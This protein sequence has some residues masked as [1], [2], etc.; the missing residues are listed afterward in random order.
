V[1]K[2]EKGRAGEGS[3]AVYVAKKGSTVPPDDNKDGKTPTADPKKQAEEKYQW[4]KESVAYLEA[5]KEFD[6]KS[7]NAFEKSVTGSIVREFVSKYPPQYEKGFKLPDGPE[8]EL[9]GETFGDIKGRLTGYDSACWSALNAGCKTIGTRETTRNIDGKEMKVLESVTSCEEPCGKASACSNVLK[10]YTGQLGYANSLQEYV[11]ENQLRCLGDAGGANGKHQRELDAKIKNLPESLPYKRFQEFA[12]LNDWKGY[13]AAV[14]KVKQE[15]GLPEPIPSPI[16]LPWSYSSPCGGGGAVP[17]TQQLQVT[18]SADKKRVKPGD[19]VKI[20]ASVTGGKPDYTYSWTGNYSGSGSS[21]TF[22]SRN[23]GKQTLAVAVK[24]AVGTTG[25]ASVEI[26]VEGIKAGI[27]GLKDRVIYGTS[28]R[29]TATFEEIKDDK[30]ASPAPP[31]ADQARKFPTED[32]LATVWKDAFTKAM[33]ACNGKFPHTVPAKEY[34]SEKNR[35]VWTAESACHDDAREQANHAKSCAYFPDDPTCGGAGWT[36]PESAKKVTGVRVVWQS[37]P[38]ITFDPA[39][40]DGT[41]TALLDRMGP[42]NKIKIW[43]EIQKDGGVGVYST[44]GETPQQI[45]TVVPPTFKWTFEPE[46]G[47]GRIGQEVKAKITTEPADIK[48]E[49][50]NYE[51]SWPESSGRM[52]YEKNASVIGFV[53]KDPKPVKLLVAPKVPYYGESIGGAIM[54][55][56]TAE[57]FSV[58]VTG[59]RQMGPAPQIWKEGVGLVNAEQQ[60]AVFQ[61]VS[62]RAEVAPD[63]EKKPLRYQWTVTPGGCTVGNDISQEIT[64]NCSQTGSFQAKVT[65]KDRDGADLGS[66]SGTISVTISQQTLNDSAKKAKETADKTKNT[67]EAKKKLDEAKAD[68]RK[69]KLDDA[70]TKADEAAALDP[71]NKEATTLAAKW[72]AEKKRVEEQLAKTKQFI[73]ESKFL[74]A[75]R[76]LI[77]AK[78]LHGNYPPVVAAD[79]DLSEKWRTYDVTER[80]KLWEVRAAN[81]KKDFKKALELAETMRKE[82]AL[83]PAA[84]QNLKQQEDW[85]RKWEAEKETKRKTFKAA[86]EKLKNYDYAGAVKGFEEGFMNAQD[87]F[88]GSEPEYTA[89]IK[90]RDEAFLKNK[91][92][93]ELIPYVQRAAEDTSSVI[94][95]DVLQSLLKTVDEA[96]GLQPNNSK[97]TTWKQMIE[98]RLAKTTTDNQRVA[99]GRK[100]L[101]AARAAENTY[102]SQASYTQGNSG[103]WGESVELSMQEH[104][105]KAVENYRTSLQYIPDVQV[106]KHI[107]ELQTT[108]EGRKRLLANYRTSKTLLAEADGLAKEARSEQ[109]FDISQQKFAGAIEKYQKSLSLYRP[110]NEETISRIIGN[111]DIERKTNAFK[112]H[113]ADGTALEQQMRIIEALAALEK[114]ATFRTYAILE[115]DW[116]QFTTQLQNLRSRVQSA[117]DLRARGEAQQNQGKI[118]EA[119]TSYEASLKQVPDTALEEHVRLLKSQLAKGDETKQAADRLWQEGMGLLNQ[120]RPSD[121]LTRFKESLARWQ[122]ATRAKYVQDLEARRIQAQTLRDEGGHLQ[123][124][125]RLQEAITKYNQSL[126]YWPDPKLKEHIAS[127]EG[128]L[129]QDQETEARRAQAK[130]LRDEGAALQQQNRIRDA[131]GKYR[132]SLTYWPD[133]QL[134]EHVRKLEASLAA[135]PS[136]QRPPVITPGTGSLGLWAGTWMSTVDGDPVTLA[137]TQ[138]SAKVT[139]SFETRVQVPTASGGTQSTS[140]KGRLDATVSGSRLT[141]TFT[142]TQDREPTGSLD[143]VMA[144]DG[145]SFSGRIGSA[146]D[147][148]QATFT[149]VG[150]APSSLSGV[151]SASASPYYLVDLTPYG[152][153]KGSPRKVKNIEVDDGSW[154]RLKATD[155]KRLVLEINLPQP[156]AA[157][158]VAFVSNLDNAH[159]VP[160]GFVT[161][162]LTVRTTSGD[163]R[164][165]IKAGVHTSEWNRGE[166][167]GA[168]HKWPKENNIGGS[169]WMAVFS[170]PQGSVVTGLRFDH[171]D[172]DKKYYHGAAAPG[173]CLRGITLVGS[174]VA[175][176]TSALTGLTGTA[177]GSGV[178]SSEPGQRAGGG[179]TV[180]AEITNRSKQNA[181]VFVES[182]TFSPTNRLA[183]GERRKVSVQMAPNGTITFK[184]GRDGQV[185]A[186]KRWDGEPGNPNRVPVVIFD[187]ANPFDKL[188]VTTGLR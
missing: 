101:D 57:A 50:L 93:T 118:A 152:G 126:Q 94:P 6:R 109:N 15:F 19:P 28:L 132:E 29:L 88:N 125:N 90:A 47:K 164:F 77:I 2:D 24:D 116:L 43:A 113:R 166:T 120:G 87:L 119:V 38:A 155:E 95:V 150:A 99:Q 165:E 98:A 82:M 25:Q 139:G 37:D 158:S 169:R 73:D 17:Q 96:I 81:E 172:T 148:Q 137:L 149:R 128:K 3:T 176:G 45:S 157:S 167:G 177:S 102:L 35:A 79:R 91:R 146:G 62:M 140:L 30:T 67:D 8:K 41:T 103:Q 184:A 80:D 60:I 162:V 34:Y 117:K 110:T 129:R 104:I 144:G 84:Q 130:R 75:Q 78:N 63:P 147:M 133:K 27:Q 64:V 145:N 5:L 36:V 115:G 114:A 52:E 59:P 153:K 53:P 44:I 86:E 1:V 4:L 171:R 111:L 106:E 9:C 65:I 76:E 33:D 11:N 18:L 68:E 138:T 156:V 40:S 31:P 188:V 122:D 108:L 181:H 74:D 20:A 134:E 83:D 14:E 66:G 183:P 151:S 16:T 127:I 187:D 159:N 161:T 54:E 61:N 23:P 39:T 180:M 22:A 97:L 7:Y 112:K 186:T 58:T 175:T 42:G 12:L 105:T 143:F 174:G 51:W 124:Q 154:V 26:E 71:A 170:L 142:A 121:A 100:Y 21:V 168:A 182:E 123:Q 72:K 89:A 48:P 163:R 141:G 55:E 179:L 69:G 160:D 49:L 10:T 70:I 173:F 32:E 13:L 185:M 46:K 178:Q 107:K 56:Y 135:G 92:L 131:I 85:A 136:D